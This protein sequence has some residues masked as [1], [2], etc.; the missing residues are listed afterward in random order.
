VFFVDID[1]RT[2]KKERSN[3]EIINSYDYL[4]N[5]ASAQDMTGLIP[6][7]PTSDEEVE[8]YEELYHFLPPDG[9]AE[10]IR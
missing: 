2:D 1:K 9:E 8:A 4:S 5:A 10:K 3:D 7:A 6:S